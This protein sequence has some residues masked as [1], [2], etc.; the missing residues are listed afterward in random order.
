MKRKPPDT[1]VSISKSP[2]RRNSMVEKEKTII[3]EVLHRIRGRE[4]V[5]M[6][7]ENL[8]NARSWMNLCCTKAFILINMASEFTLIAKAF[9]T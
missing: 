2:E 3:T 4:C 5:E 9:M 7:L 1:E 8:T 6:K